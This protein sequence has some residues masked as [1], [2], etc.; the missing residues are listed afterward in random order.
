MGV[1]ANDSLHWNDEFAWLLY[2]KDVRMTSLETEVFTKIT[3]PLMRKRGPRAGRLSVR[4]IRRPTLLPV[5]D[6]KEHRP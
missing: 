3:A 5:C 4:C 2:S 1:L 6:H